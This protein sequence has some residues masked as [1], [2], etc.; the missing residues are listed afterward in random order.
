MRKLRTL[1]C[2]LILAVT[3]PAAIRLKS[4]LPPDTQPMIEKKYG[5]WSGVLR[6]WVC[7]G[8]PVGAGSAAGWVNRCVAS[9]EKRHPGVY[10]QPEAVD[11]G[12]LSAEGLLPPDLVLFP[13]GAVEAALFAPLA[14]DPPLRDGLPRDPRAAPVLLSGYMWA[15]NAGMIDRI[16][17]SWRDADLPV[18][19]PDDDPAHLWS[20]ALL[21]LCSS[22]YSEADGRATA[23]PQGEIELGLSRE[24]PEATQTPAPSEGTRSCRLPDDFAPND[25]WHAFINGAAA[26]MP[27]TPREV[28]RLEALSD[29]GKGPDWRLAASGDA[30]FTDQVLY[31]GAVD[32]QNADKLALCRAFIAHLLSDECQSRLHRVGAFAV[33]GADSGYPAGD[34]LRAMEQLLRQKPLII[35]APFDADWRQDAS[36]IVRD[37]WRDDREPAVLLNL[38]ARRTGR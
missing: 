17:D 29:Q 15:Y 5:G 19:A 27:V 2:L 32:Q 9:F 13:P 12:A 28:R 30:A 37:F 3:I 38:L 7:E 33:T 36:G 8:W 35:P 14:F 11:V 26:A 16:P 24:Q 34:S 1:L 4:A 18:A 6:L 10:L 31:I 25:A 22:K 23:A 20:A 21:A